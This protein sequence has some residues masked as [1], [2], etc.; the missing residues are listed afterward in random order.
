[1]AS[2][3]SRFIDH[4]RARFVEPMSMARHEHDHRETENYAQE[5]IRAVM[6]IGEA[7]RPT[8]RSG[9]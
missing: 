8:R 7:R 3:E 2:T 6:L 9:K 5:F 1:M 4:L